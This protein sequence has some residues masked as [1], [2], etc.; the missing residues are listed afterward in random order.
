MSGHSSTWDVLML[1]STGHPRRRWLVIATVILIVAGLGTAWV[2]T[3]PTRHVPVP[4]RSATP[5]EVVRTYLEASNAHD[6]ATMNA[7][8]AGN[9]PRESRF[10]RTWIVGDVKTYPAAPESAA[11]GSAAE[12]WRQAV[13]V[14]V[15]MHMVK[16]DDMNMPDHTDAYWGYILGRQTSSER[17]RIIDQGVG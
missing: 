3:G 14:D 15:D 11:G 16:G 6:V 2:L 9:A 13:R 17:W 10:R 7:L 12:G 4:P 8:T 5:E 1:T